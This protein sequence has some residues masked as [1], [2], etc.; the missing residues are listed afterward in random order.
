MNDEKNKCN[1]VVGGHMD[2]I[3]DSMIDRW[4]S[5]VF[6]RSEVKKFT[7]GLI[8]PTTQANYD[9]AGDGPPRI[10]MGRKVVYPVKEYVSWLKAKFM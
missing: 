9:S 1:N 10:K 8:S 6:V 4:P 7:G 5:G 2:F 3:F